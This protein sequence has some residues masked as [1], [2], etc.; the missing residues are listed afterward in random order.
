MRVARLASVVLLLTWFLAPVARAE[1]VAV[2]VN[3]EPAKHPAIELA[4]EPWLKGRQLEVKLGVED[5][6]IKQKILDC[7]VL[8]SPACLEPALAGLPVDFTLFVQLDVERDRAAGTEQ[9]TV[10]GWLYGKGGKFIAAQVQ[11]C[12]ACR[13]DTLGPTAEDM[14]KALFVVQSQGNGKIK[15]TS[16]PGGA[17]VFVDG[18]VAGS[19]P[20][21][22]GLREGSHEVA[23]ELAG[24]KRETRTVEVRRDE[25]A[26]VDVTLTPI[27]SPGGAVKRN[28]LWLG[29]AGVG[30]VAMIGGGV[31]IA[32]DEDDNSTRDMP[33]ST[34]YYRDSAAIGV[35]VLG[36]GVVAAAVG[37]VFYLRSGKPANGTATAWVEPGRGAGVGWAG[38]F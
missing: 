2:I 4:L 22:Q 7:I 32:I 3:G 26:E 24:H 30:V 12:R 17:K 6:A 21:E 13:N 16:T 23:F 14:A 18:A 28:K 34:R 11:V 27:G 20:W 8:G 33:A 37:T 1:T 29:V 25:T 35:G 19:T 38:S 5:K 36:A 31:L 15:L 10:T 9:I